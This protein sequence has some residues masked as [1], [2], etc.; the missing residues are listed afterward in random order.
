MSVRVGC[1]EGA[2]RKEGAGQTDVQGI[3]RTGHNSLG[4]S[5]SVARYSACIDDKDDGFGG[6]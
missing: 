4:D 2:L 1:D 3:C 5:R 6:I